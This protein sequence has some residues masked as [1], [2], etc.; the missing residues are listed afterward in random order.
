MKKIIFALTLA[1]ILAFAQMKVT[2]PNEE[3]SPDRA[4]PFTIEIN[5][6]YQDNFEL[7]VTLGGK[8]IIEAINKDTKIKSLS[9]RFYADS[10]KLSFELRRNGNQISKID[11]IINIARPALIPKIR[12]STEY[13]LGNRSVTLTPNG[14]DAL[15]V[16]K[17]GEAKFLIQSAISET[18]YIRKLIIEFKDA[19]K[20][21]EIIIKG[22]PLWYEPFIGFTGNFNSAEIKSID[23]E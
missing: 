23:Y 15:K 7:V 17:N 18:N 6:E 13:N 1:P 4:I 9:G 20:N 21:S 22:S 3:M 14:K 19:G 10:T 12:E 16:V 2:I 5:S 11:R 8:N